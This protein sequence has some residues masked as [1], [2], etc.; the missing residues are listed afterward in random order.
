MTSR[1]T[2]HATHFA[3]IDPCGGQRSSYRRPVTRRREAAAPGAATYSATVYY[4]DPTT[5]RA[6]RVPASLSIGNGQL[7]LT[8][9]DG[10]DE[11]W[12]CATDDV[13]AVTVDNA[14]LRIRQRNGGKVA[15]SLYPA[16]RSGRSDAS[17]RV[18]YLGTFVNGWANLR[19]QRL[20]AWKRA[21]RAN[22]I[23]VTDRNRQLIPAITLL[24]GAFA[25]L[26]V[27]AVVIQ[28]VDAL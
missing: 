7:W 24:A 11:L 28:I 18:L 4:R 12:S 3:E 14:T 21:L 16:G 25:A 23:R 5:R 6:P 9:L 10:R 22:G 20:A 27:V 17:T 19:D 13:R 2:H 8:A 26:L 15:V 1:L